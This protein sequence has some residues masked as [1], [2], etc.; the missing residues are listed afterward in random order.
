MQLGEPCLG[1][2]LGRRAAWGHC[3]DALSGAAGV[4]PPRDQCLR[5][6]A[7]RTV[8]PRR[9]QTHPGKAGRGQSLGRTRKQKV[10]LTQC[11]DSAISKYY[12]RGSL[13]TNIF[14]FLMEK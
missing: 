4:L 6:R 3:R 11:N 10:K 8:V 2:N 5:P 12:V 1:A 7:E 9:E 14:E 13:K